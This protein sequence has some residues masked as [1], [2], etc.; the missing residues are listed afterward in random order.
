M[1]TV[2]TPLPYDPALE[3]PA[4]DEAKTIRDLEDALRSIGE[5]TFANSGHGLRT[6]HAKSHALLVG[7]FTVL[8]GLPAPYAQGL[9]AKPGRYEAILRISRRHPRR[10]RLGAARAGAEG[11]RRRG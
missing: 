1:N 7:T 11:D 9:F 8:D 10:R 3:Q 5:T 2:V 4:P 6:V